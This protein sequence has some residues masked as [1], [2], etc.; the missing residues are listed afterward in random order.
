MDFLGKGGWPAP[1][2][3]DVQLGP[4]KMKQDAYIQCVIGMRNMYQKCRLVHGDL[5]EYNLLY[6]EG[7]LI[8]ID[9]SQ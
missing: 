4:K 6:M 2:L 8:F 3:R 5:S 7:L 9:V 1:R